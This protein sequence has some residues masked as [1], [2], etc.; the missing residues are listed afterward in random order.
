MVDIVSGSHDERRHLP[1]A[2]GDVG[3]PGRAQPRQEP[4]DAAAEQVRREVDQHVAL[5]D[6]AG[7]ADRE[8]SRGGSAI[9]SCTTQPRLPDS[10]Q[11]A[12]RSPRPTP[13][14]SVSQPS[15]TP[16]PP[17]SSFGF[18]TKRSRCARRYSSRSI[19][20]RRAS[21]A[22]ATTRVHGTC[23][24]DRRARSAAE[25]VPRSDRRSAPR[26]TPSCAAILQR[27]VLATQTAPRA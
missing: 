8:R 11:R 14:S 23:A 1:A 19:V 24:R 5:D 26:R 2:R 10:A 9:R 22:V 16:V 20:C 27:R 7:L 13:R 18:S 17:Y 3:Q 15:V 6:A 25:E 4:G 12:R 21:S